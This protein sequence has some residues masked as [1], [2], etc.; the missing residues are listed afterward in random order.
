MR[1]VASFH[2]TAQVRTG[3]TARSTAW[4]HDD[5]DNFV[6]SFMQLF[7]KQRAQLRLYH[8]KAVLGLFMDQEQPL[9]TVYSLPTFDDPDSPPTGTV[10]HGGITVQSKGVMEESPAKGTE[11]PQG[12]PGQGAPLE[13]APPASTKYTICEPL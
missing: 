13:C 7:M 9:A 11:A 3:F 1:C 10:A 12:D 5:E 2:L 6:Q 8:P 4:L